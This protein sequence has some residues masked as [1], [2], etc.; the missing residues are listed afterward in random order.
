MNTELL[1]NFIEQVWNEGNLDSVADYI[2]PTY[3]VFHDPGDPWEGK[4]LDLEG[5]KDRVSIS[6]TPIPDQTFRIQEIYE[7]NNTV[8]ITWL[9]S[10]THQGEISGFAATGKELK[11]SGVTVYY[12]ESGKIKGH[13]QVADRLSIYQQLQA[14]SDESA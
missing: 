2:A 7:Q 8:C 5:F 6:R 9:W 14:F 3:T 11:M 1:R 13:W 10:G 4:T 12:F